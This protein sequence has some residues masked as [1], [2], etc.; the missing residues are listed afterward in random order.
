MSKLFQ[1]V[2][3]HIEAFDQVTQDWQTAVGTKTITRTFPRPVIWIERVHE[4]GVLTAL[5][6]LAIIIFALD[7]WSAAPTREQQIQLAEGW[8]AELR[9]AA[10]DGEIKPRD[11]FTLLP[12]KC[13]PDG[14]DWGIL[15]VDV[16]K[17][18]AARGMTWNCGEIAAHIYN[19]V[20]PY[21]DAKRFSPELSQ[22]LHAAPVVETKEQRQDRRLK[23]CEDTGLAMP[24][25][26]LGRLPYGVGDVAAGEGV[27]RQAYTADVRAALKRREVARREGV[28]VHRA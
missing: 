20:L 28:T 24:D 7:D 1:L 9:K 27:T 18:L 3:D 23:A 15:S 2:R 6:C 14:W 11:P 8:A 19:Q 17:F 25:S 16:D 26:H 4:R 13:T 10:Q 12:L 22:K 5:D 21:I